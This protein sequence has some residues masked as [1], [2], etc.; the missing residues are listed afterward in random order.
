M[1]G[2]DEATTCVG[3]VIRNPESGMISVAH[4]DSPDI[5]E[6]GITQMLSSIVDSKYAIL[7]V[8]LVGGFNDVSHQVSANFSNC[9]FKVFIR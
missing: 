5:V 7:D 8:H 1:V 2:T 3:L 4:V 6:I 9:V